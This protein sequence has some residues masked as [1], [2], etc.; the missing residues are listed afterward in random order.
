[1]PGPRKAPTN[2]EVWTRL[3]AAVRFS[4]GTLT[5]HIAVTSDQ[6]MLARMPVRI[7]NRIASA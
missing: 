4:S 5:W 6:N 3:V 1:M 2:P 7:T